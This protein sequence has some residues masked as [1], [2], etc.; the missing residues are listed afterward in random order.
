[1]TSGPA[2]TQA[3]TIRSTQLLPAVADPVAGH[4]VPE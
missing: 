2:S 1:M 4:P 3:V